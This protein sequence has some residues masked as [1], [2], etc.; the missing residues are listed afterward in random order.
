MS[1]Y[2][3]LVVLTSVKPWF[4]D[5]FLSGHLTAA[6][7][8]YVVVWAFLFRASAVDTQRLARLLGD[9]VLES[10]A[11][12]KL[13]NKSAAGLM[14]WDESNMTKAFRGERGHHISL[15]RLMLLPLGWW[16]DF[17][18]RLTYV[19]VKENVIDIAASF[20]IRRA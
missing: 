4:S 18:P 11:A 15:N 1:A 2:S 12:I 5:W 6:E 20:G 10:L 7:V 13:T 9:T 14:Q 8:L 17:L 19:V 3:A 16:M